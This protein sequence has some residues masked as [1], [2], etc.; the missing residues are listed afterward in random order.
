MGPGCTQEAGWGA[1]EVVQEIDDR[2]VDEDMLVRT[3]T[4][5]QL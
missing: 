4:N 3:E 1:S 5:A 2:T